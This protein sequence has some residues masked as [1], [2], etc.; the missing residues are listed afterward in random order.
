MTPNAALAEAT[1]AH[2]LGLGVSEFIV[3]AGARNVPLVTSILEVRSE[4]DLRVYHHFDERTASFFA[5]GL[6]KRDGAPVAVVTTSGT[7]AAELLPATIE[8]HYSGIPLILV[9][10]DRPAE[11][12][13]SGAPQAIVQPGLFGGYASKSIDI[14]E[15]AD[16]SRVL[17]W[18]RGGPLHLNVCLAEPSPEDFVSALSPREIPRPGR[19]VG[20]GD[21][22]R[23]EAFIANPENLVVILGEL[24]R[25]WQEPVESFLDL[26]RV[27]VWAEATSGLRESKRLAPY[28]IAL[29]KQ[30]STRSIHKVLRIGGVPS[31]RFWRDLESSPEIEVISVSA[32]PYSG[33]ARASRHLM[34]AD[35]P[36]S[37]ELPH[38]GTAQ[39]GQVNDSILPREGLFRA[40]MLGACLEKFP[41]AEPSV[42]RVLSEEIDSC[43]HVFLGNSLPIREWNLAASFEVGHRHVFASRGANGIDGQVATY[44][45]VSEGADESWGIFGDLT[46]LYDLNA[47]ALLPLLEDGK[48]R[49]VI[50]NNGGG[51]I[52]SRLSSM[53]GLPEEKKKVTENRHDLGFRS[54]AAL[55][56]IGHVRWVAGEPF[57]DLPGDTVILEVVPCPEATEGFWSAW[58]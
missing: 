7:A 3:C 23:L 35:F 22:G 31:L 43:A 49:I 36:V 10:A 11:Y 21:E 38:P 33:L 12:R 50:I 56:G 48:R 2:L 53:A 25:H 42:F 9:T 4:R 13:G 52:F 26:L 45:G 28:R 57:P 8:A 39:P 6:A 15:E 41:Q 32:L 40:D 1:L 47:P 37:A 14:S 24:P 29:E 18:N 46:A 34:T 27:P 51:R 54:W 17:T 58:K 5:I 30:L 19:P 55:W 20:A 16:L 44:L